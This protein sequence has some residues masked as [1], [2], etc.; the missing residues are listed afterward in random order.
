MYQGVIMSGFGGQGVIS[1]GV[2]L[3]YSGMV[4]GK[5]V[6]FFPAYGAEMRGGTA[7]CSVVIS[8]DE[9]ASP[10]VA[11]PDSLLVMNEPSLTRFEPTVRAGGV[12]YLNTS[13]VASRSKRNDITT[14]EIPANEIAEKLGNIKCANMVMIGAFAKKSGAITIDALKKSLPKVYPRVSQKII[15]MN[16]KAIQEGADLIK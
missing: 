10:V 5:F 2:L 14:I 11:L 8:S 1:G 13:L 3:A 15:D 7:N 16:G 6:T 9:V 12:L 4:D